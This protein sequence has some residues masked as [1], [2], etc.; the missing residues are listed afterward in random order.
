MAHWLV[1]G[2]IYGISEF[3]G[4]CFFRGT[5]GFVRR[6]FDIRNTFKKIIHS[7]TFPGLIPLHRHWPT[8]RIQ[9]KICL[10]LLIPRKNLGTTFWY[11]LYSGYFSATAP[12]HRTRG[13]DPPRGNPAA[14]PRWP[15][16]APSQSGTNTADDQQA[17][18]AAAGC[19]RGSSVPRAAILVQRTLK[20]HSTDGRDARILAPVAPLDN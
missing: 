3:T 18:R 2:G 9:P 14:Q 5:W 11:S 1:M 15:Y 4:A 6:A 7:G 17:S 10:W 16:T 19:T 13:R 8:R 12:T 20:N